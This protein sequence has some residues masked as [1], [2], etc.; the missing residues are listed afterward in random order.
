M[1]LTA[2]NASLCL[3]T[4][5]VLLGQTQ[6]PTAE[7]LGYTS[8]IVRWLTGQQNYYGGFS[9]TQDTVVA[10]Q[11]LALY[12]TLVF[13][14]EGS[15]TVTVQSPSGQLTFDVNQNNNLLYQEKILQDMTGKYSLEV[16]VT[17]CASMQ[18]SLHYNISTP[19]SVTTLSVEVIPEAICTS[20]SQTSRPK[21]TL[22]T[23]SLYSGKETTT[24]MVILDIK[25][26][27]GF[28]PDPES[29][30]QLPKD[31]ASTTAEIIALPAEPEAAV[32]KIYDYYQPS[33]Q[34]ETE[35]TYPCA[36]A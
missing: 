8:R 1:V 25:M 30:K 4:L 16:K 34:A 6:R 17:A 27:S 15:S 22:T 28:A 19:T 18:I 9:S 13:S 35:Y 3:W 7:D 10:L 21:F 36:A 5:H 31:E 32:V 26:L 2:T 23:K 20:K 33:D 12:S 24:N 14:P 11:A 29:L